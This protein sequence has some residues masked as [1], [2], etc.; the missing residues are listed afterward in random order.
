MKR[1]KNLYDKICSFQN[2][3]N[4]VH[5]AAKGR[6]KY[7]YSI[8]TF[9]LNMEK[10]VLQLQRELLTQ[11]YIPS[12][13]SQFIIYDPKIRTISVAKFRDRVVYHALC[14]YAGTVLDN[15]LISDSYAC[16]KNKGIHSALKKA[17]QFIKTN[18]YFLKLD[19]QKFFESISHEKLYEL[20]QR[21]IKDKK[22]L[23]LIKQV[24]ENVPPNYSKGF[25]LPIGNLTSQYF[26]NYFLGFLDHYIKQQLKIKAYIRY[27]D[28]MLLLAEDKITLWSAFQ[29]IYLYLKDELTL[30]L[31][32]KAIRLAP[33]NQ[34]IPFL[35]F[36]IYPHKIF[37]LKKNWKR[38]K[39]KF[40]K[41]QQR[42]IN[43]KITKETLIQSIASMTDYI[44]QA[45][46][47]NL[48]KN[49]IDRFS[50]EI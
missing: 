24:I 18:R 20:I 44:C 29:E 10:E 40:L 48:R 35:G 36:K 27:M 28:D 30:K 45:D 6:K 8:A 17:A 42:Y 34:G 37:I 7:R 21:K 9:L 22:T 4:S 3:V 32:E 39:K 13:Y 1:A 2:L 11:T 25:G 14:N 5:K 26:G 12:T 33:V 16:R 46:T 41:Q 15:T 49:F 38:F 23:W 50:I 31:N 43:G 47:S 19:I